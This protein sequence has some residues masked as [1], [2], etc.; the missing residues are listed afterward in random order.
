MILPTS[1]NENKINVSPTL[2]FFE[3]VSVYY[4]KLKNITSCHCNI[5]LL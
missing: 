1:N 2:I 5:I 3:K 4:F